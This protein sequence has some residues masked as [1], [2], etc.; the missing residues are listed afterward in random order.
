MNEEALKNLVCT[1]IKPLIT[2]PNVM[3]VTLTESAANIS[4]IVSVDS[5]DLGKLI[6]YG[7]TTIHA[8]RELIFSAHLSAGKKVYIEIEALKK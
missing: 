4:C 5:S 2:K 6:G 3:T 8:I 7:G 1:I